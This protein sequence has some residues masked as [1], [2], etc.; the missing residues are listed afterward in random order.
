MNVSTFIS[1]VRQCLH[2]ETSLTDSTC[3]IDRSKENIEDWRDCTMMVKKQFGDSKNHGPSAWGE[4]KVQQYTCE[5]I[6]IVQE[7]T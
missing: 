5:N 4:G 6:K 2:E 3:Q 7:H 1:I